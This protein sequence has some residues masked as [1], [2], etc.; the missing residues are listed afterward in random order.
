MSGDKNITTNQNDPIPLD[1]QL[2]GDPLNQANPDP[3]PLSSTIPDPI[4]LDPRLSM[5]L[6]KG[7]N[8]ELVALDPGLT[9]KV[10]ENQLPS[11]SIVETFSNRPDS[12]QSQSSGESQTS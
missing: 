6:Q 5:I 10:I 2:T 4:A 3:I 11:D 9:S 1:P 7:Q 8:P 12:A